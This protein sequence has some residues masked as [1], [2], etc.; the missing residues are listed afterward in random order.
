MTYKGYT[1]KVE[2]DGEVAG[3]RDVVTFKGARVREL[4]KSFHE[5]VNEGIGVAARR[6]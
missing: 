4:R 3:I 1:G 6:E 2:Y 5:S